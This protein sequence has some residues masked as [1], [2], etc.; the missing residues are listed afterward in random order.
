[1]PQSVDLVY[2]YD[3]SYEGLLTAVFTAFLRR[4]NP[5]DILSFDAPRPLC[6]ILN[7]RTDHALADRVTRGLREKAGNRTEALVR[8]AFLTVLPSKELRILSFIRKAMKTGPAI[9]R[10]LSDD[11]VYPLFRAVGHAR[12]EAHLFTGFL[13]FSE[14]N[15]VLYAVIDPKNR[16]LPLIADHFADR[17]PHETFLIWDSTHGEAMLCR[18]GEYTIVAAGDFTPPPPDRTERETRALWS[19]FFETLSI[20][21]RYNPACQRTHLPL[22]YRTH[23]TEFLAGAEKDPR[24]PLSLPFSDAASPLPGEAG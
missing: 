9:A 5:A 12:E 16:V 23:M 4:E 8:F 17:F 11:A 6:P 15:G 22:R 2:L 10:M 13:R 18:E 24:S 7:V 1:M 21:A 3:G 20:E 14:T 19:R